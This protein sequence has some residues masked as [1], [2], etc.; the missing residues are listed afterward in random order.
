MQRTASLIHLS[1]TWPSRSVDPTVASALP[2]GPATFSFL[3]ALFQTA[4]LTRPPTVSGFHLADCW[5]WLRY[6]SAIGP[7]HDLRLRPEWE[8][9]DPHQKTILSDD[10]GVGVS[11]SVVAD[12]LVLGAFSDGFAVAQSLAGQSYR[13]KVAKQGPSKSPDFVA[14]SP[15]GYAVL[16]FKG[17][18]RSRAVLERAVRAGIPQ[19]QS[20]TLASSAT[21]I[22]YSLVVGLFIP[23][24]RSRETAA[25]LVADPPPTRLAL[26]LGNATPT[27]VRLAILQVHIAKLLALYGFFD[28]AN[29]LAGQ[30]ISQ[31]RTSRIRQRVA[32]E[33]PP[34]TPLPVNPKAFNLRDVRDFLERFRLTLPIEVRA[35]LKKGD[36][37]GAIQSAAD[38]PPVKKLPDRST[39]VRYGITL[40]DE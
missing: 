26:A 22:Q 3:H 35:A 38:Y 37:Y 20:M 2:S 6:H 30:S 40:E 28:I 1:D 29:E 10:L 24:A 36:L 7:S 16:E 17:T 18:Q 34:N 27:E 25:I 31:L 13:Q 23:Q 32:V 5:A 12:A 8:S 21:S 11:A 15:Q 9:I 33:I 4:L 39:V 19:K 14:E